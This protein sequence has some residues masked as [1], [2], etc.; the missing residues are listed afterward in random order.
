MEDVVRRRFLIAFAVSV[1]ASA[2]AHTFAQSA[3][4]P[5]T[6]RDR[7]A[8]P[9]HARS[10]V[11][12]SNVEWTNT[13]IN[14]TR[15]QPLR[16]EASGEI[17]L[18]FSGE[19]VGRASGAVRARQNDKAPIPAMPIGALIGRVANGRPFSIGDTT[20]SVDMPANGRLFLGVNDD[21]VA[22]NSGNFVV[23]IWNP[24]P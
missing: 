16:F 11:V 19:D 24:Q 17:L 23:K 18:S 12:P 20:N 6:N 13:G 9:P 22:D 1:L 21:H 2:T 4:A 3:L 5:L 15:G 14:V 7:S 8:A 10:V